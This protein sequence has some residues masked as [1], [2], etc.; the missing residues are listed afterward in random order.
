MGL[1][2]NI[3]RSVDKFRHKQ[4]DERAAVKAK[5]LEIEVQ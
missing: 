2:K 1:R 3:L 5:T 4:E